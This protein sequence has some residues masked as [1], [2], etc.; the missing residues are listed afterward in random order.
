MLWPRFHSKIHDIKSR[1]L[2][3]M[4]FFIREKKVKGCVVSAPFGM[5]TPEQIVIKLKIG[6]VV[7]HRE[8]SQKMRCL[9]N[10]QTT[11]VTTRA[12]SFKGVNHICKKGLNLWCLE[13]IDL[14]PT[15]LIPRHMY[16]VTKHLYS[17]LQRP[18]HFLLTTY[19][20]IITNSTF[21]CHCHKI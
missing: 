16:W 8:L 15:P 13:F 1:S 17:D 12:T 9:I 4:A 2:P 11:A 7:G 5:I 6:I 3:K 19:I 20:I 18:R 14:I 10:I 21:K